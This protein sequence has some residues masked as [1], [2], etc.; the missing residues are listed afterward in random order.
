MKLYM[1]FSSDS[2]FIPDFYMSGGG[3]TQKYPSKQGKIKNKKIYARQVTL[4][5]SCTGLEKILTSKILT[6]NFKLP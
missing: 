6:K 1:L 3:D 4:K 2:A 5:Y